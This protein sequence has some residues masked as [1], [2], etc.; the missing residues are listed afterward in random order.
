VSAFPRDAERCIPAPQSQ[1][2]H[3]ACPARAC[4]A[5][6]ARL[7]HPARNLPSNTPTQTCHQIPRPKPA[8]E[9]GKPTLQSKKIK[10]TLPSK[11][12]NPE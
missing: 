8:I 12:A 4:Q 1:R 6:S 7:S 2:F 5:D 9:D 3:Y 11:M 10:P